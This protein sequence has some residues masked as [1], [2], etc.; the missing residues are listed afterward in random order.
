MSSSDG[1]NDGYSVVAA[2]KEGVS[3]MKV[4]EILLKLV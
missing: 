2:L 1:I 3:K 4:I